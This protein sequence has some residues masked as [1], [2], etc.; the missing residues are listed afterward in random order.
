MTGTAKQTLINS[1]KEGNGSF[2]YPGD[3]TSYLIK[4]YKWSEKELELLETIGYETISQKMS[5]L[6]EETFDKVTEYFEKWLLGEVRKDR[7]NY[8]LKKT[9]LTVEELNIWMTY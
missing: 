1:L 7:L 3:I 6:D 8:W 9:N 5:D 4:Y 2:Y